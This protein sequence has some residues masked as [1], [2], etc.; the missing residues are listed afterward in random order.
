MLLAGRDPVMLDYYACKY[1][2]YAVSGYERHDPDSGWSETSNPYH[3]GS[4]SYGYPYNALRQMLE[5][6]AAALQGGG[7]DVTLDPALMTV[8]AR[9]LSI[10]LDGGHCVMGA[11]RPA[12]GL[13][14]RRGDHA[15]GV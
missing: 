8:H 10:P 3:D 2:L 6:N 11:A 4:A 9:D 7:H 1:V 5:S 12:Q 13:V 14:L 15:G